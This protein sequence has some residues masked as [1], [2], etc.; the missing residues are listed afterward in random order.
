MF[1]SFVRSFGHVA[2]FEVNSSF[3]QSGGMLPLTADL[4]PEAVA[5]AAGLIAASAQD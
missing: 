4:A 3:E 5:S 1:S 2:H